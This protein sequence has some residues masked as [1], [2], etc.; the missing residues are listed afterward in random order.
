MACD[1]LDFGKPFTQ[2]TQLIKGSSVPF[3]PMGVS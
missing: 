1:L 2:E 3:V